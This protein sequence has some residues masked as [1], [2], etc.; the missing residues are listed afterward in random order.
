MKT[1]S[2]S[3]LKKYPT[4]LDFMAVL[5]GYRRSLEA[6]ILYIIFLPVHACH[7]IEFLLNSILFFYLLT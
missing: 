6:D 5:H 2:W 3:H 1:G 7:N 4:I